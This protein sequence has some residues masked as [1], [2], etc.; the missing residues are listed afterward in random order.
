ML[1]TGML[2]GSARPSIGML[3]NGT[4]RG[5]PPKRRAT[6]LS[7]GWM[8]EAAWLLACQMLMREAAGMGGTF[9]LPHSGTRRA[10][11]RDE[12]YDSM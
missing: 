8:P 2:A 12:A 1:L 9:G 11:E 6:R 3:R 5:V 10:V 4:Q 7:N